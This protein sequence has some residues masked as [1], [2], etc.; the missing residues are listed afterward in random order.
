M[1]DDMWDI[2]RLYVSACSNSCQLVPLHP[3][4]ISI[5][6]Y[7]YKELKQC[8]SEV[9]RIENR[10]N[11]SKKKEEKWLTM[12]KKEEEEETPTSTLDSYFTKAKL[13]LSEK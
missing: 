8:I 13:P 4:I 11:S 10:V 2:P 12:K 5:L 6:F 3:I 7:H 1:F 9:E